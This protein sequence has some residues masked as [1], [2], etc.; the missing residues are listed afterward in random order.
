MPHLFRTLDGKVWKPK[1]VIPLTLADGT[2]LAGLWGGSAT[3]EKLRSWLSEPGS[4]LTR[5]AEISEVASKAD[6][7]GE[8]I[9]GA[10]PAGARLLFVLKAPVRAKTG[11]YYRLAKMVTTA[12]TPAQIAYFRHDRFSLFG[13]LKSDGSIVKIPPVQPPPPPPPEQGE[14]F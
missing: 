12:A 14:L 10:A 5:S 8:T 3:E 6:D 13:T 9:W 2:K 1:Q 11:E 4:E 7:N